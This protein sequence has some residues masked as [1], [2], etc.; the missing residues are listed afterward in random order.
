MFGK[1]YQSWNLHRQYEATIC[2]EMDGWLL[3]LCFLFH[4]P[5]EL[6]SPCKAIILALTALYIECLC[7]FYTFSP[8]LLRLSFNFLWFL[9]SNFFCC[10]IFVQ[11]PVQTFSMRILNFVSKMHV[12][13]K[14]AGT[15]SKNYIY[16][17]SGKHSPPT[18]ESCEKLSRCECA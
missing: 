9:S 11:R 5:F 13:Q 16:S 3:P 12:G 2:A 7:V 10:F 4:Y 1:L 18:L 6:K 17:S 8:P 14:V 15:F